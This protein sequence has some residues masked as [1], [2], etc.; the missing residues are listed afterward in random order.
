LY[1]QNEE[2]RKA[3]NKEQDSKEKKEE[4]N[5]KERTWNVYQFGSEFDSSISV[6]GFITSTT[7]TKHTYSLELRFNLHPSLSSYFPTQSFIFKK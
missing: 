4:E 5:K 6:T 7:S 1:I 3:N 2:L